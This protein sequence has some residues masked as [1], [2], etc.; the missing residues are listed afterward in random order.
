MWIHSLSFLFHFL[1]HFSLVFIY[2][3]FCLPF[4]ITRS[5]SSTSSLIPLHSILYFPLF[6]I[7]FE[8]FLYLL[9]LPYFHSSPSLILQLLSIYLLFLSLDGFTCTLFFPFDFTFIF[10][11]FLF[12]FSCCLSVSYYLF[13][14]AVLSFFL[15]LDIYLC[16]NL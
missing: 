14:P 2:L 16:S 7:Y 10:V 12:H 15:S 3:P 1:F 5:F 6:F 13:L 8:I 11:P 9:F 4:I